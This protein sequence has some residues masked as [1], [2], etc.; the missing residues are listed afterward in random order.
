MNRKTAGIIA[1]AVTAALFVYMF[2][3]GSPSPVHQGDADMEKANISAQ[4]TSSSS[5]KPVSPHIDEQTLA[6]EE[7]RREAGKSGLS[8]LYIVKCSSCHGKDGK[9]PVGASIAGKDRQYNMAAIMKYKNGQVPNTLMKGL[10][11]NTSV[12]Q[13]EMLADEISSFK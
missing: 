9:G 12:E 4:V 10:L 8:R 2:S 1:V 3:K 11:E 5:E 13:L 7:M 6:L